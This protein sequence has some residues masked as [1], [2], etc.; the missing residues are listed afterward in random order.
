LLLLLDDAAA[1]AVLAAGLARGAAG[2]NRAGLKNKRESLLKEVI[3]FYFL[4]VKLCKFRMTN[5]SS[6]ISMS[7]IIL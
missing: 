6:T 7:L 2:G 5:W 4:K 3:Y 1:E